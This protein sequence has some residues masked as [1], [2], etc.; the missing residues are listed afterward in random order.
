M[1]PAD[2]E[3]AAILEVDIDELAAPS[4][5]LEVSRERDGVPLVVPAFHVGGV[6]IWGATAMVLAEFL[7]LLGWPST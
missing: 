6:E 1:T 4:T 5:I 7:A 2:G 3:V